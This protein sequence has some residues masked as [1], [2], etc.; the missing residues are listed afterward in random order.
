MVQGCL[1]RQEVSGLVVLGEVVECGGDPSGYII[2]WR[3]GIFGGARVV[4]L[5]VD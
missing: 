5:C 3:M 4:N 1:H 2:M